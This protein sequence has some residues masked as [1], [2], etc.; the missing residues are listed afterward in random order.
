MSKYSSPVHCTG[1]LLSNASYYINPAVAGLSEEQ[2]QI[3]A[4]AVDFATRELRP[5][6][7][8]WDEK[9]RCMSKLVFTLNYES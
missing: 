2:S 8:E 5:N 4:V 7:A 3:Q 9:V 6:M 1:N